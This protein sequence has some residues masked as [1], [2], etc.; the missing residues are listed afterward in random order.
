MFTVKCPLHFLEISGGNIMTH[1]YWWKC[2]TVMWYKKYQSDITALSA[3]LW[4]YWVASN[5]LLASNYS[6]PSVWLHTERPGFSPW[7]RERT[8]P[9]APVSTPALNPTQPPIQ[10]ASWV[11]RVRW[12][13]A[14]HTFP[15][16][17]E[18][19]NES[20]PP[21]RLCSGIGRALLYF[22]KE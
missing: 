5:Y 4:N 10:N 17:A 21:C 22:C 8:Y 3:F 11:E 14:D 16:S 1:A 19:R 12:C 6:F 15:Y 7:H 13:D 9:V 2:N 18:D 20:F